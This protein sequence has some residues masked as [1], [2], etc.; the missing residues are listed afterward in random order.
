METLKIKREIVAVFM[1][2][3]FYFTIPLKR[4]LEFIMFF[5]QHPV[6]NQIC[7]LNEEQIKG[8]RE[9]DKGSSSQGSH[10]F[11][12]GDAAG[13]GF[14]L[15]PGAPLP[16]G[17]G[18]GSISSIAV[19]YLGSEGA[20]MPKLLKKPPLSG[21]WVDKFL[22]NYGSIAVGLQFGYTRGSV[23]GLTSGRE[24]PKNVF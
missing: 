6:Y 5:S 13:S 17:A 7:E 2:S 20:G 14:G 21:W 3:P 24:V 4:R 12:W 19:E 16:G 11:S 8:T 23:P 18:L 15:S 10:R 22:E 1:E 9:F